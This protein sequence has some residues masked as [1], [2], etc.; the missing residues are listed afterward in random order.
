[1]HPV[2][3]LS[4]RDALQVLDAV[5]AELERDGLGAAVAVVDAH[6]ELLAFVRTD[7][8]PLPSITIACNKAYSAARQRSESAAIGESSI[9]ERFP[10]TNFGDS[11]FT[12]WG[13]GVPIFV[14]GVVVG[15][16]GVS[17]LPE[18]DDVRLAQLGAGAL[19]LS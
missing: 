6:G 14:D 16:I 19:D 3:Q 18:R 15:A 17:G 1:M 7:D 2:P 4:H 9:R 10:L 12:G 5:L 11:R 13:G 8:C